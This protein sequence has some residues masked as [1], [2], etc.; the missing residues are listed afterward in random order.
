[1]KRSLL[2]LAAAGVLA[3]S[4]DIGA[5]SRPAGAPAGQ[6]QK[7]RIICKRQV[8]CLGRLA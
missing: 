8:K 4:V 7:H 1:M 3:W 2:C 6:V 5:Q